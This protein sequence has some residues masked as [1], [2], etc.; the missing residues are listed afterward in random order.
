[1]RKRKHFLNKLNAEE[2]SHYMKYVKSKDGMRE[3]A[4]IRNSYTNQMSCLTCYMIAVKL[5]W[6]DLSK[7]E[8]KPL[9]IL[10]CYPSDSP[11][12]KE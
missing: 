8:I 9:D 11:D 5:G 10:N 7:P 2:R 1:M 6:Q 3:N 12:Y 4:K